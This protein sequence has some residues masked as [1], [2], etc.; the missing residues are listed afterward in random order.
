MF[1]SKCFRST[2]IVGLLII[3]TITTGLQAVSIVKP[4]DDPLLKILPAE[5]LFCL[6]VN[7]LEHT[8]GQVD[9]F[10]VG[11]SPMPMGISLLARMQLANVLGSPELNG[12]DIDLIGNIN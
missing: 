2:F 9:Q 12:V 3:L 6:R 8:I 5:S 1:K 7:H 10:L 4:S 11:V